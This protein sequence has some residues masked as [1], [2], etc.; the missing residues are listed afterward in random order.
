MR[1]NVLGLALWGCVALPPVLAAQASGP[2]V[3]RLGWLAG[4]WAGAEPARLVEE[5]WMSPRAGTMVGMSRT[6]RGD[7]V[8]S[9]ELVVLRATGDSVVYQAYPLGQAPTTFT[10]TVMTD[11]S[12]TFENPTHDFPQRVAYRRLGTDSLL[13]WI[14]GSREGRSRRIDFPMRRVACPGALRAGQTVP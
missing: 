6:T 11:T 5:Q 12:V 1:I 3:E 9:V 7:R 2:S 4:C 14:E 8:R 13:A 10:A